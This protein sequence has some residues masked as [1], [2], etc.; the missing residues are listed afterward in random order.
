MTMPRK[1]G[2]VSQAV[3]LA[4]MASSIPV[5][6]MSQVGFAQDAEDEN[7]VQE[8]EGITVT[9]SRIPS[10]NLIS[11]SPVTTVS[12]DEIA[13]QGVTRIEDLLMPF[14][15]FPRHSN[16]AWRMA[17]PERQ[18]LTFADLLLFVRWFW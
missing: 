3:K 7:Q 16:P 8:L 15:W 12:A 1:N 18:R 4:L 11:S 14:R 5:M 13:F 9:G 2:Q 6:T 17:P 10:K